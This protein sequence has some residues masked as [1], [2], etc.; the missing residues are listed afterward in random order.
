MKRKT[1]EYF[2][3]HNVYPPPTLLAKFFKMAAFEK[4]QVYDFLHEDVIF[5]GSLRA[6]YARK[7]LRT[8]SMSA[9]CINYLILIFI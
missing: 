7:C 6:Q 4:F 8:A 1:G 5:Q 9:Q 3:L 2:Y